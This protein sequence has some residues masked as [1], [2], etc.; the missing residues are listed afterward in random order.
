MTIQTLKTD[1]ET[2]KRALTPNMTRTNIHF[3]FSDENEPH[4]VLRHRIISLVHFQGT[5]TIEHYA[6]AYKDELEN[7]TEQEYN[8][9]M[10]RKPFMKKVEGFRTYFE[11]LESHRCKCGK[12]GLDNN[13]P[14]GEVFK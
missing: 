11:W 5:E 1:V 14:F 7:Y 12:H 8:S 9:L 10:K 3:S 2:L 13:Q 6:V 4:G